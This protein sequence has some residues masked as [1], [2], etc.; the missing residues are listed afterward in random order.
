M[1]KNVIQLELSRLKTRSVRTSFR[2]FV[3]DINRI[4]SK[5]KAYKISDDTITC[6]AIKRFNSLVE[7]GKEPRFRKKKGELLGPVTTLRCY[8]GG[9][10][11][12]TD[13]A[14]NSYK[15]V[16]ARTLLRYILRWYLNEDDKR[17]E[18]EELKNAK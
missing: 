16:K 17:I 1:R 14:E 7:R 10:Q 18:K 4:N 9:L 3:E 6:R 2:P 8:P 11:H 5:V 13:Y 15:K 12:L